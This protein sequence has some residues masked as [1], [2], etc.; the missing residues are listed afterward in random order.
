MCECDI[1]KRYKKR[2]LPLNPANDQ[3][4]IYNNVTGKWELI[5]KADL[6]GGG[7]TVFD[8]NRAIKR[9]PFVGINVGGTDVVS[10]L[11]NF[12]FPAVAPVFALTNL[13]TTYIERG[14]Y[15]EIGVPHPYGN[16]DFFGGSIT[17]NDGTEV[18]YRIYNNQTGAAHPSNAAPWVS[19]TGGALTAYIDTLNVGWGNVDAD[20]RIQLRF[21]LNGVLQTPILSGLK[22][23]RYITP[24]FVGMAN[25]GTF[26]LPT[27]K[28][29]LKAAGL[30]TLLQP[31]VNNLARVFNGT[32]K[33]QIIAYP[34]SLP[35]LTD[36][37]DPNGFP[38]LAGWTKLT[39]TIKGFGDEGATQIAQ[40]NTEYN[41]KLYYSPITT[42][43]NGTF[44]FKT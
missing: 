26:D 39:G 31:T 30:T 35:D 40:L 24:I 43:N 33:H 7:S 21:K 15:P 6:G 18:E 37:R 12:F 27:T 38:V 28:A 4:P 36:I 11:N 19:Y 32:D 23:L 20:W 17:L 34:A 9:S 1:P 10:F 29:A 25:A 5:N 41:Y 14:F 22:S 2:L 13:G 16:Y 42:V 44:T 3:L 8:G